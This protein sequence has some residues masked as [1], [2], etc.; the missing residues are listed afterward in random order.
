[1]RD[2]VCSALLPH[3][4]I[5]VDLGMVDFIDTDGI[6]ALMSSIGLVHAVGGAMQVTNP[7]PQIECLLEFSGIGRLLAVDCDVD[8]PIP[9]SKQSQRHADA[10]VNEFAPRRK[11]RHDHDEPAPI[12]HP[13]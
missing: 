12:R 5:V 9:V 4:R 11:E 8:A 2:A 13:A 3:V 7:S 10:T 1:M 6:G